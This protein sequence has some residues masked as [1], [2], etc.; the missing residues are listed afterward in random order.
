M[1]VSCAGVHAESASIAYIMTYSFHELAAW[2]EVAAFGLRACKP[3]SC[4]R[5]CVLWIVPNFFKLQRLYS[6]QSML[7]STLQMS[8]ILGYQK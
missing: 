1:L 6:W 2:H 7:Y 5:A 3:L 4:M 8:E